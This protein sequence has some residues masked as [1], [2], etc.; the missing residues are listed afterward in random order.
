ML[1][2]IFSF[3]V[4]VN[5]QLNVKCMKATPQMIFLSITWIFLAGESLWEN[6]KF[7]KSMETIEFESSWGYGLGYI[8]FFILLI[9]VSF[10]AIWGSVHRKLPMA[11]FI[12]LFVF[13]IL[14]RLFVTV[15]GYNVPILSTQPVVD[16]LYVIFGGIT[17]Y[18]LTKNYT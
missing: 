5:T 2:L 7:I 11:V 15:G 18:A 13:G 9:V 12:V 8:S 16:I 1:F 10:W 17:L 14:L 6:Y 4:P 3:L